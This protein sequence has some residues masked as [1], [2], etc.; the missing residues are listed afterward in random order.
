MTPKKKN[1]TFGQV[2]IKRNMP[3]RAGS[4]KRFFWGDS[5]KPLFEVYQDEDKVTLAEI[6]GKEYVKLAKAFFRR[7]RKMEQNYQDYMVLP[8]SIDPDF[9]KELKARS[10]FYDKALTDDK[11]VL[12]SWARFLDEDTEQFSGVLI[13]SELANLLGDLSNDI[14]IKKGGRNEKGEDMGIVPYDSGGIPSMRYFGKKTSVQ[15]HPTTNTAITMGEA[16]DLINLIESTRVKQVIGALHYLGNKHKKW[17]FKNIKLTDVMR[18]MSADKKKKF[19]Q[20]EKKEIGDIIIGLYHCSLSKAKDEGRKFYRLL[21][22]F[23]ITKYAKRLKDGVEKGIA[24]KKGDINQNIISRFSAELLPHLKKDAYAIVLPVSFIEAPKHKNSY[25]GL[26]YSIYERYSRNPNKEYMSKSRAELMKRAGYTK[27][28]ETNSTMATQL[29]KKLLDELI[30]NKVLSKYE[31]S[32]LPLNNKALI[33]LYIHP[34]WK[35]KA[36]Q[37]KSNLLWNPH[38]KKKSRYRVRKRS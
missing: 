20:E 25:S 3:K 18:L 37:I 28:N 17:E 15:I 34:E 10:V 24:Y 7:C 4:M 13:Q 31:P 6:T 5:K 8:F 33:K 11:V 23:E 27:T 29:L 16:V 32:E 2:R 21:D 22:E 35:K 36:G 9:E 1:L 30:E 14:T 38:T 12:A 26:A 19:K